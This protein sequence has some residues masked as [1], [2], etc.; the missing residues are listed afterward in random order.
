[1]EEM[2]AP[3]L[4]F[5]FFSCSPRFTNIYNVLKY[6]RSQFATFEKTFYICNVANATK[7]YWKAFSYSILVNLDNLQYDRNAKTFT[8]GLVYMYLSIYCLRCERFFLFVILAVQS[9][10]IG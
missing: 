1:M 10:L 6:Y 5:L 3:F 9:H 2:V 7:T 4:P 8:V